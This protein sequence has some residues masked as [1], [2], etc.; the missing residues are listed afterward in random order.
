MARRP[1]GNAAPL[2]PQLP[3]GALWQ[4]VIGPEAI[5]LLRHKRLPDDGAAAILESAALILGRCLPP[6]GA[7]GQRT[8][9][10]VGHVQS[11][12]TL[13]FTTVIALA[14]DNGIP[15][16]IVAAGTK[17]PLLTQTVDRLLSDLR[18]NGIPG[19]PRWIHL[20]LIHI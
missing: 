11:G 4:P 10:V 3:R 12:K 8:G 20:S 14:R 13:S 1:V 9:L 7:N 18:V 16:V 17:N 6:G 15:L 5:E 19:P 2:P